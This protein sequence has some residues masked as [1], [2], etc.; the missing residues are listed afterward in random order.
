MA[1]FGNYGPAPSYVDHPDVAGRHSPL[2]TGQ[3]SVYAGH[4][5]AYP[6]TTESFPVIT[7][8]EKIIVGS[9]L[10]VVALI[11][12]LPAAMYYIYNTTQI[13]ES[14][15][16]FKAARNQMKTEH[17]DHRLA[18]FQAVKKIDRN[19]NPNDCQKHINN[20][21]TLLENAEEKEAKKV[22]SKIIKEL[23]H[24]VN[25][26]FYKLN[27]KSPEA[28]FID[29][30][31]AEIYRPTQQQGNPLTKFARQISANADNDKFELGKKGSPTNY[32][33]NLNAVGQFTERLVSYSNVNHYNPNTK[34]GKI[35]HIIMH[36]ERTLRSVQSENPAL[37]IFHAKEGYSPEVIGNPTSV[38]A[39]INVKFASRECK[40][41]HVLGGNL[42]I[43]GE[44]GTIVNPLFQAALKHWDRQDKPPLYLNG[45]LQKPKGQ[46]GTR[47][48]AIMD[49]KQENFHPFATCVDGSYFEGDDRESYEVGSFHEEMKGRMLTK[50]TFTST[51]MQGEKSTG[52]NFPPM[53]EGDKPE[54]RMKSALAQTKFIMENANLEGLTPAKQ[55]RLHQYT[56]QL[57]MRIG[58]VMTAMKNKENVILQDNCKEDIDRGATMNAL[59]ALSLAILAGEEINEDKLLEIIAPI[60][61]RAQASND[62]SIIHHRLEPFLD[63]C[64][65]VPVNVLKGALENHLQA[66]GCK[67]DGIQ[68]NFAAEPQAA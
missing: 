55:A 41:T 28:I 44:R 59:T 64:K 31:C 29:A 16:A 40:M 66:I 13:K 23:K 61:G 65:C 35:W 21:L 9:L 50:E 11:I 19:N 4:K 12:A 3:E 18:G 36:L 42:T 47:V 25:T 7:A 39:N 57:V 8:I 62:R 24:A 26:Q 5:V 33:H 2:V 53:H 56:L 14:G 60:L 45:N 32:G 43:S 67:P 30:M 46:E 6:V 48:K 68:I 22:N 20:I 63:L 34:V 17:R 27:P 1:E 58:E 15:K 52:T 51:Y 38:Y 37:G 54:E 10:G 49:I